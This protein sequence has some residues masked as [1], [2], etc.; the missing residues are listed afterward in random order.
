MAVLVLGYYRLLRSILRAK[1][2]LRRRLTRCRRCRI[3]FL[4]H[5]CNAG[6]HDLR[7][8][9]GCQEAHW[10]RESTQRSVA[11]YRD[12]IG[13]VKKQIQNGKRSLGPGQAEGLAAPARAEPSAAMVKHLQSVLSGIEGRRVSREEVLALWLRQ[14]SLAVGAP[15]RDNAARCNERPP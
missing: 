11:Y 5:A 1:P 12:E 4:A 10:R 13:R 2:H 15:V 6:R 9:F 7:C 3:F 8:P 14:H